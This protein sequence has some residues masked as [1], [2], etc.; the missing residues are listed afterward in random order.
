MRVA[1]LLRQGTKRL[2]LAGVAQ[3]ALEAELLLGH[4]LQKKRTALFLSATMEVE[5]REESAF[6]SL[7]AR[8]ANHEPTAYILGEREFWSLPFLVNPDVL[9]PRPETEFLLDTVLSFARDRQWR[10]SG[11]L[12][13]LC[14]GSGVIGVVLAREWAAS[15]VAV[16]RS[17]AALRVA[18]ANAVRHGVTDRL[19]M[20]Q[21]DLMTPFT[22]RPLFSLIVANPP[23]VRHQELEGLL[24]PEVAHFEP[25]LALDGGPDGLACIRRIREQLPWV[26]QPGGDLFMEIGA[27][28]GPAVK[29]LFAGDGGVS[30]FDRVEIF[31]DYSGRDRVLHVRRQVT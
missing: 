13:D 9:I 11:L 31:A 3:P 20:I 8:R 16:D 26:L 17:A 29:G 10:S 24:Q 23:Y 5:A 14:C 28:Q 27:D 21:A 12:L 22:P 2:E 19:V 15:V 18:R 4:C 7:L 30:F 25:R 1:E 6:L